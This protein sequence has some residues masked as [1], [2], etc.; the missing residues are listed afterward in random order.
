MAVADVL[1]A[2]DYLLPHF[3]SGTADVLVNDFL[4]VD[5][6]FHFVNNLSHQLVTLFATRRVVTFLFERLLKS[7]AKARYH[8]IGIVTAHLA[9]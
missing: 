1:D 6:G 2:V 4:D 8:T 7:V 3:G 5:T 9:K